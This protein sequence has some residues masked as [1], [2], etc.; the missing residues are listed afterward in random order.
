VACARSDAV[1]CGGDESRGLAWFG[2]AK[3]GV[4][5]SKRQQSGDRAKQA[6]YRRH[7]RIQVASD[8][9]AMRKPAVPAMLWPRS[10]SSALP[11]ANSE[12]WLPTL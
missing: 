3:Q 1:F 8:Y 10:E 11:L 6:R 5:L 2:P 4:R 7:P 9:H 12:V